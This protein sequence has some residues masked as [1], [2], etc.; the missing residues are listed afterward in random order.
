ET[1]ISFEQLHECTETAYVE[2]LELC[3]ATGWERLRMSSSNSIWWYGKKV[4]LELTAKVEA[5]KGTLNTG[6]TAVGTS[7]R[8]PSP[9]LEAFNAGLS[10]DPGMHCVAAKPESHG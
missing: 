1:K 5:T 8:P 7:V 2:G 6:L 3:A 10:L 9:P 4:V